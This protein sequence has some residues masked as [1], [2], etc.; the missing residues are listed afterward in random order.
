MTVEQPVG[1]AQ[2]IRSSFCTLSGCVEVCHRADG[3]VAVRDSK[4]P[5]GPVL[6]FTAG[7]WAD[8]LAGVRAGEFGGTA[9]SAS[10]DRPASACSRIVT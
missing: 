1:A 6:I 2:F 7:E 5:E 4:H 9:R 8:F 3:R 10:E